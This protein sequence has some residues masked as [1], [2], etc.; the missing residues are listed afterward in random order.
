MS[1]F[2]IRIGESSPSSVAALIKCLYE[3][4]I[5][6]TIENS[7]DIV[8][9]IASIIES[10]H[11]NPTWFATDSMLRVVEKIKQKN[12]SEKVSEFVDA[13]YHISEYEGCNIPMKPTEHFKEFCGSEWL[14]HRGLISKSNAICFLKYQISA[15][16]LKVCDTIVHTNEWLRELIGEDKREIYIQEFPFIVRRFFV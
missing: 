16:G 10:Q 3:T 5:Q 13:V 14:D 9:S 11:M 12:S 1:G 6:F 7:D 8:N 4:G 15:R 2:T